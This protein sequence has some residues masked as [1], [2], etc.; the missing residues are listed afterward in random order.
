[1]QPKIL[2]L[3]SGYGGL[4]MAVQEVFGGELV[5]VADIDSGPCKILAHRHPDVPNLG[6]VSTVDWTTI[7]ADIIC[8]GSPCQDLSTAGRR[9]GMADGTRSNLW[10]MMREGIAQLRPR[11]VIWENVRGAY[12]ASAASAM[13]SNPR[14]LGDHPAGVPALRALGRVLGDLA[15]LG[16]DAQWCGLPASGVGAPHG[17]FRVFLLAT[18]ATGERGGEGNDAA[19]L[20][21]RR[22]GASAVLGE[23]DWR[24][25]ANSDQPGLEGQQDQAGAAQ[26]GRHGHALA[27]TG[28]PDLTLLPTPTATPYGSNQ[29]MSP[30]AAV[31]PSLDGIIQLLPTPRSS[32]TNGAGVHGNGGLDLRSAVDLLPTPRATNMENRQSERF[33]GAD[34]NFY[35]LLNGLTDWGKYADAIA[36]WEAIHGPAPVPTMTSPR[37]GNQQLSPAFTEW[38]MGLPAG[39]ITDVPGITRTEALKACGN[40]VV[41]QQAEAALRFMLARQAVAA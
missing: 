6:D 24:A 16:Y 40:G 21:A 38:M 1:M 20:G 23:R 17:R 8:G 14:L 10:V 2:S 37:S 28:G 13:E 35:G 9:A 12:S 7:H 30:G 22:S 4:D 19:R 32:D 41:P 26:A 15:D 29:S 25:T 31:R 3:F 34:G 11:Y 5:A 18:D 33:R 36:R 39:W 27:G